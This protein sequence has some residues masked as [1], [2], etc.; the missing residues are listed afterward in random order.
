[1]IFPLFLNS[2]VI[3]QK[4]E[5]QK[6]C[7][8]KTK[9]ANF[10]KNN[11]FLPPDTHTNVCV[12]GGKKCSLFGKISALCFL[13]TPVLRFALLPYYR[14]TYPASTKSLN[15]TAKRI[16]TTIPVSSVKI[17]YLKQALITLFYIY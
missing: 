1:M 9:H 7:F 11:Y 12:S 5:C 8:K 17:R 14:Q 2:S 13:G 16:A 6:G 15:C 4:G 10:P 3:R